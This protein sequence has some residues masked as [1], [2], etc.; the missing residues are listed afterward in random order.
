MKR[1]HFYQEILLYAQGSYFKKEWCLVKPIQ[2]AEKLDNA[3]YLLELIKRGMLTEITPEFLGIAEERKSVFLWDV[4][5]YRHVVEL[6]LG[7]D[8]KIPLDENSISPG[9]V[10]QY[11]C[12]N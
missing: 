4:Y 10:L 8:Q 2:N 5:L 11:M 7:E 6:N 12:M 3:T 1:K 9:V